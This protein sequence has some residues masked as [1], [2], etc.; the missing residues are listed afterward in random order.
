MAPPKGYGRVCN[1]YQPPKFPIRHQI[2][3]RE[4]AF[5]EDLNLPDHAL[6]WQ[7]ASHFVMAGNTARS[8]KEFWGLVREEY[9]RSG[10]ELKAS[11]EQ[12]VAW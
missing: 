6:I 10:G 7:E 5:T 3:G 11:K 12:E 2:E 4:A 9:F 1:V 8:M